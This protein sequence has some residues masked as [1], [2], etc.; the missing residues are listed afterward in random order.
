MKTSLSLLTA[1]IL[2]AFSANASDLVISGVIDG[3]LTGGIPKAV[4]LYVVNDIAD[5][6]V[7]GIGTANNGGGTD[8][9]EFTFPADSASAGSYIY[10]ASEIDGF[11]TFFG[12]APDYDSSAMGINGDDAIELFQNDAVVDTFGAIDV[13]GSGE[14]WEYTDGWAYRKDGETANSGTFDAANW[15]FSGT[16]ALDGEGTNTAATTAFPAGTFSTEGGGEVV[17]E[18]EVPTVELGECS[19]DAT[20]IS[21][22][23]GSDDAS[24]EVGNSHIVEAVITGFRA[25]GF[26]IQEETVQSD[27]DATTSEGLF[28]DGS[29]DIEAGHIIR[30]YGEVGE[31]YGLTTLTMDA[32]VTPADCGATDDVLTTEL[33]MPYD[34]DL[35]TLEG[36]LVSVTDATVTSQNNLWRYGELVVSD[37]IKRQPSDVAAP[38]S[39]A[40]EAAVEA[41][42]ASLL[43]IE[44][45][46]SNSY[47]DEISYFPT[48]SYANAIRV[49]DTV[50]AAGPLNYS[51]GTYRI[52]P[53]DVITVTSGREANPVV[54]EGNLSIATFNVLNYFNGEVTDSG[55]VT[56]DYDA[57]RG[58]E[59]ETEFAL[60]E[61]RIVEAIVGLNADVVGLMEIENDGFGDDSAIQALVTAINAELAEEEQYTFVST[62]DSSII[63]TDAITVGLLYR[64]SVVVP[65]GDAQI[66]DMP[67]QQIDED[68]VAQMR[69]A[70]VQ[71][72]THVESEKT[73]AVAVNHFKS[74]GSEC[75]E[76]LAEDVS[77]TDVIQGSC[78]ALRVSAAIT[79][80]EALADESMP[81]RVLILGD[82]NAYSAE[83]PVA[84]LTDY[85]PEDRGYTIKTAINTDMDEGESVEVETSYGYHNLAE[86]FDADGYS[87]WYYGTEQV[88]SLDHV[89]ASEAFLADAVDGAH[90]N[91][92]SPEVYQ[93]T[94]D[95]A[96]TYYP[97]E[98]G[99]A[100]TDV[101]PYKS[102]DHDPFIATFSLEADVE[103]VEE[104]DDDNDSG[105][106]MGVILAFMAAM[107]G[108]RRRT[109]AK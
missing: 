83:D 14:T 49:G 94:Y 104:E 28:V 25:D 41:A 103:E 29:T 13:D 86:E 56:F 18:P 91:I 38:L 99:Y 26:F 37:S 1:G 71:T 70:L 93:L 33:A 35:E 46:N 40:Y 97:D 8:G 66:V 107:L 98:D 95:Q 80:A 52:N 27:D 9:V 82:L 39:E 6:S 77:D 3:P 19:T 65:A 15:T 10:V 12:S 60:Q 16:D 92:N 100:F 48:F 68:S 109:T 81:E 74:K 88:G 106:S 76:D 84:L 62:A 32:D 63:G 105:G 55:E 79:L 45:D 43:T 101:G 58:A 50:T 67:I 24:A 7:Y 23:Q 64:A 51:F 22:I 73:F 42:E 2:S 31:N 30:L 69:A 47:P 78:N 36:M 96:L 54:T 20:L 90:W 89:L 87:Y 85:T 53:T 59:D 5:L 61:G 21:A 72:F 11:T 17:V 44:D 57:N 102:S 34:V 4:E 75:A 108:F